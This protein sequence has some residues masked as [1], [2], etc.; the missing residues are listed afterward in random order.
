[1]KIGIDLTS[2]HKKHDGGKEQVLFN[3]LKGFNELGA[4]KKISIF[5]YA[6][7][8]ET[9]RQIIPDAEIITIKASK[10]PKKLIAD[11]WVKTFRLPKIVKRHGISILFFPVSH[12][13][14]MR[15]SIPT[16]VLPHDIQPIS[17]R[18]NYSVLEGLKYQCIYHFDF[19]LRDHIVS[20]SNFDLAQLEAHYPQHTHKFKQIYNPIAM[21]PKVDHPKKKQEIIAINIQYPHK[22][23]KTLIKAFSI[24]QHQIPHTLVLV[25]SKNKM[26]S[27]LLTCITEEKVTNRVQFTGFLSDKDLHQRL[28]ESALYVNPSSFEGFGM[29][30]IEAMILKVP[31]IVADTTA[32]PE[33]TKGLCTYY[34][35]VSDE[36]ALARKMLANLQ[37]PPNQATLHAISNQIESA[38]SYRKIANEYLEF[39]QTIHEKQNQPR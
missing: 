38:Y 9:I 33:V 39:F 8:I 21:K 34:S 29:T 7:M 3:L 19:L 22:N 35:P 15:F 6:Y 12:T 30:A 31:V 27:P 16:V 28:E 14:L 4:S 36:R 37:D 10:F 1:M 24:I 18:E 11:Y 5:C 25:G 23:I 26:T 20:I 32:S 17:R 2:F 13:G